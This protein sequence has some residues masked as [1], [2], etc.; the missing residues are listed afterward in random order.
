M[1]KSESYKIS[2]PVDPSKVQQDFRTR[3]LGGAQSRVS[4]NSSYGTIIDGRYV[5]RSGT[6][7]SGLGPSLEGSLYSERSM[8]SSDSLYSSTAYDLD[9]P[10]G[11]Y[12]TR[13]IEEL[14]DKY[15]PLPIPKKGSKKG[16]STGS[17][18]RLGNG[19]G[20]LKFAIAYSSANV[21]ASPIL[22]PT[23][24]THAEIVHSKSAICLTKPS[25]VPEDIVE[26]V[27]STDEE[28]VLNLEGYGAY[29]TESCTDFDT[30]PTASKYYSQP[31][32]V[33]YTERTPCSQTTPK[34]PTPLNFDLLRSSGRVRK[35][36]DTLLNEDEDIIAKR[37]STN[38][39]TRSPNGSVSQS[40]S[41]TGSIRS[42]RS[43]SRSPIDVHY[44][45]LT[46]S[47][48]TSIR[49]LSSHSRSPTGSI[50]STRSPTLASPRKSPKKPSLESVWSRDNQPWLPAQS[51]IDQP[52]PHIHS[53]SKTHNT[54]NSPSSSHSSSITSQR[55]SFLY[56]YSSA[57]EFA[58]IHNKLSQNIII[59]ASRSE[60]IQQDPT[61]SFHDLARQHPCGSVDTATDRYKDLL[62]PDC[63]EEYIST[64]Y[65]EL[66][67]SPITQEPPP[68]PTRDI[69]V[70]KTKNPLS[71]PEKESREFSFSTSLPY[72]EELQDDDDLISKTANLQIPPIRARFTS[73]G[74]DSAVDMG[75]SDDDLGQFCQNPAD[76]DEV[77]EG[78]HSINST[79]KDDYATVY[80]SDTSPIDS[81]SHTRQSSIG[82]TSSVFACI[83]ETEPC[84]S[85]I[86]SN[87][88]V[89]TDSEDSNTS[90]KQQERPLSP[91]I[92]FSKIQTPSF[93]KIIHPP[94]S[95]VISDHSHDDLPSPKTP[96]NIL[97]KQFPVQEQ[98]SEV[99]TPEKRSS[100]L[101]INLSDLC[102]KG[103]VSLD[104]A[105]HLDTRSSERRLSFSSTT[106]EHSDSIKSGLSDSSYSIDDEDLDFTP[107]KRKLSVS[108]SCFLCQQLLA[109]G[110]NDQ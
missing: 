17:L 9:R 26:D 43:R 110:V 42:H 102:N 89:R 41:P 55:T 82:A 35:F 75:A 40:R 10:P 49:S 99:L 54:N 85:S 36:P 44:E 56:K 59:P 23:H 6:R 73:G 58:H 107:Y 93:T 68:S 62:G 32:S 34:K 76:I 86:E 98:A 74:S 78:L 30:E 50:K 16:K 8:Y 92:P 24:D 67:I 94:P 70:I 37:P 31:V 66:S 80:A 53:P 20:R 11:L 2:R 95:V 25:T 101:A 3:S 52:Q 39:P 19:N 57:G 96:D 90:A 104:P 33:P 29:V 12:R 83:S 47:P 100:S 65:L 108:V 22:S 64:D 69:K 72:G 91:R 79:E 105:Y 18:D 28:N 88:Q 21:G 1:R 71:S 87:H 46:G 81:N 38:T 109:V 7:S 84:Q 103:E 48:T 61:S 13:S 51:E 14:L 63:H 15:A 27:F 5:S 60:K 45:S 4:L 97:D 106:S 77:K